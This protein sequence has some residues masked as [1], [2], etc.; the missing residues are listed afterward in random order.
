MMVVVIQMPRR[1]H[2]LKANIKLS[3]QIRQDI[4][5]RRLKENVI[6]NLTARINSRLL[7]LF[8]F[9]LRRGPK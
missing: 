5:I 4:L 6:I 7:L 1:L 2:M 9:G 8:L 3:V